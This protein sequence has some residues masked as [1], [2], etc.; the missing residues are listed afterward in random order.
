MNP[1]KQVASRCRR[2]P[3]SSSRVAALDSRIHGDMRRCLTPWQALPREHASS[4]LPRRRRSLLLATRRRRLPR[5]L[6]DNDDDVDAVV[7]ESCETVR[8][9]GVLKS[10]DL[11]GSR[12]GEALGLGD[13]RRVE[14]SAEVAGKG[15]L[16]HT[17]H[18][19]TR[20]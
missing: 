20:V 12:A 4:L 8:H 2:Y 18:G 14:L 10:P 5:W 6:D 7:R 15:A 17:I 16:M 3:I 9:R 11:F 13:S 1:N 19:D